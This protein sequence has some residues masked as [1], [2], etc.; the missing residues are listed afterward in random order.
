M[1]CGLHLFVLSDFIRFPLFFLTKKKKK[2]KKWLA[3]QLN[4][5]E[6]VGLNSRVLRQVRGWVKEGRS[7]TLRLKAEERCVF[8]REEKREEDSKTKHVTTWTG[9]G[10]GGGSLTRTDKTVTTIIDYFW[11]FSADWTLSVF[12]GNSPDDGVVLQTRSSKYEIRTSGKDTPRPVALVRGSLDLNLTWLLQQIRDDL[13]WSF[14]I[15]RAAKDT[16]TPRRNDFVDDA[17]DFAS[18]WMGWCKSVEQYFRRDLFPVQDDSG[19]LDLSTLNDDSVFMPVLPLMEE[20]QDAAAVAVAA[21]VDQAL[22]AL[23]LPAPS[24]AGLTLETTNA[25]LSEHKRSL[26]QKSAELGTVFPDG[27]AAK[28]QSAAEAVLILAAVHGTRLSQAYADGMQ[29]IEELVRS[30]V[31]KAIGKEVSTVDFANYMVYHGRQLFKPEYQPRPFSYAVRRPDHVPEGVLA[32][33]GLLSDGSAAQPVHTLASR[34]EGGPPM[35]FTLHAAAT[36]KFS[37]ETYVHGWLDHVFSGESSVTLQLTARARQFSSFLVLV[38]R[39]IGPGLFDP[40]YGMIVQ[41]KDEVRIPLN[42][43]MI[44]SAGEFRD[45][46]QSLSDEQQRFATAYRGMQLASSLFGVC[47]LQIKPQ[48]ERL[49]KLNNDGLTKE[50]RLT[51]DLLEMFIKYQIPSDLLSYAG[52]ADAADQTK[53]DEVKRHVQAMN[54]MIQSMQKTEMKELKEQVFVKALSPI[55]PAVSDPKKSLPKK[56]LLRKKETKNQKDKS[57]R[58]EKSYSFDNG[59]DGGGGGGG[60]GDSG[61]NNNNIPVLN[62]VVAAAVADAPADSSVAIV[63]P[64]SGG[65]EVVKA[66]D[67]DLRAGGSGADSGPVRDL[68]KLPA[69]LDERFEKLDADRALHATLLNVGPV[70]QKTS[71]PSL[72][73]TATTSSVGTDQQKLEKNACWDLLD[74]LSKSGALPFQHA[75]MHVVVATSHVFDKTVM[76]VLVQDNVNPIERVQNSQLIIASTIHNVPVEQLLKTPANV[77]AVTPKE[78]MNLKP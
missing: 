5:L 9:A 29:H 16:H 45:A 42:K 24:S 17:F 41:N 25:F 15:D 7:V 28:V 20:H 33:E 12:Q 69:L 18:Q 10:V 13:K 53:V 40:T 78:I 66:S 30:Q 49:L 65:G 43:E 55:K 48:L 3:A 70:W 73:A 64:T 38:G 74:A 60:G 36:V 59:G 23:G 72:L 21:Q 1:V 27:P 44:P 50:I 37:G 77:E 57:K 67:V 54:S 26:S 75:S 39:I 4:V 11:T 34:T 35:A 31:V 68:T 52:P 63:E 51:Q 76:D 71:K 8:A 19:G 6:Q 56:K 58:I 47:V 14:A 32:L 22:V 46:V 62:D 61:G 2:K